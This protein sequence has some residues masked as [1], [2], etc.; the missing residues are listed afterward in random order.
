[1][2]S[3]QFRRAMPEFA[4]PTRFPKVTIDFW[5]EVAEELVSTTRWGNLR[6]KGLHLFVAHNLSLAARDLKA[7]KAG[8][9]PGTTP[10]KIASKSLGSASI[11]YEAGSGNADAGAGHWGLT[12]Y[13]QQYQQLARLIG[14]GCVVL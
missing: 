4:D 13:G 11:S 2:D 6:T 3:E 12:T 1:M 5:A 10:G 8:G 9:I 14:V 7:S